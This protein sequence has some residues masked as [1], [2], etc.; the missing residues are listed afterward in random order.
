[1][2]PSLPTLHPPWGPNGA[3]GVLFL[4]CVGS[5]LTGPDA[6]RLLDG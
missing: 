2:R 4:N 5:R 1:M 3:A 6:D